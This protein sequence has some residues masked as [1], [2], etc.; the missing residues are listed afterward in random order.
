MT[1]EGEGR[2]GRVVL[3]RAA[4]FNLGPLLVQPPLRRLSRD[5]VEDFIQ[6]RVMQVL[7]CARSRGWRCAN[8]RRSHRN[9]LGGTIVTDDA[10]NRIVSQ[11]HKI[12]DGIGQ[13]AFSVETVNR[14]GYRLLLSGAS[15]RDVA[16]SDVEARELSQRAPA[17]QETVAAPSLA[18][19][20]ALPI[21]PKKAWFRTAR[22]GLALMVAVA[23]IVGAAYWQSRSGPSSILTVSLRRFEA[24]GPGL[25]EGVS[26]AAE[27]EL[28]S[29]FGDR[30]LALTTGDADLVVTGSVRRIG[31]DQLR[32]TVV[33]VD[34]ATGAMLWTRELDRPLGDEQAARQ[35]ARDTSG[36]LQ[37]ALSAAERY[38]ARLTSPVLSLAFRSCAEHTAID[39]GRLL[40]A[41]RELAIAQPDFYLGWSHIA[42]SYIAEENR[43]GLRDP[44]RLR[45]AMEAAQRVVVLQPNLSDGYAEARPAHASKRTAQA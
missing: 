3:G 37:C 13:S 41:A 45:E 43:T 29:S 17:F 22:V 6:P 11:V 38:S 25:P 2:A 18:A 23:V 16:A 14:V 33:L 42:Y 30:H 12:A 5:G 10:L 26:G 35:F 1:S 28:R 8:P 7:V 15:E 19:A 9:L 31:P 20:A 44:A 27:T 39:P 4:P 21:L 24:I 34:T 40:I 32:F 36:T